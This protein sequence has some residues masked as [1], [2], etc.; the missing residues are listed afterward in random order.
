MHGKSHKASH[1]CIR[2]Y[3]RATREILGGYIS[4]NKLSDLKEIDKTIDS[5]LDVD[6]N[7]LTYIMNLKEYGLYLDVEND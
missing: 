4:K 5:I 6:D 7:K 3:G 1:E 2:L